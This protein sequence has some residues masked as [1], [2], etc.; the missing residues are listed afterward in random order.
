M[1]SWVKMVTTHLPY[2]EP[3]LITEDNIHKRIL[4]DQYPDLLVIKAHFKPCDG[5]SWPLCPHDGTKHGTGY[6]N[7]CRLWYADMWNYFRQFHTVVRIDS[8]IT[9][10]KVGELN[11]N[12]IA[13]PH[14]TGADYHGVTEGMHELFGASRPSS[15]N[16]YT[17]VMVVNLTWVRS[18]AKLHMWFD[19]VRATNCIC[20]NRWGDLP[21]WG[22]TLRAMSL[23]AVKLQGWKYS[24]RSH[25][26]VTVES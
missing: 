24:H 6:R 9:L 22:E 13:S 8:D 18:S 10:I 20:H 7:M 21:L 5:P 3:V 4:Q 26:N 11:A 17:N 14:F 2:A 23:P 15:I 16:P 12:T 1:N 25:N 19:L